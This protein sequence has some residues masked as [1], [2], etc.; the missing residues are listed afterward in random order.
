MLDLYHAE[1]TGDSARVLIV[2]EEKGVEFRSHYVDV[3]ALERYRPPLA[4]IAPGGELP[5]LVRA[6]VASTGASA[7]CELLEEAFPERA[8]M[9][10]GA[11]ERWCVR[12]WQKHV[13]DI[14][15][16]AVSVLAWEQYRER[17]LVPQARAELERAL[18]PAVPSDE[19]PRWRAAL[20]G[21]GAEQLARAAAHVAEGVLKVEAALGAGEWL[22][23]PGYSLAD[24]A[25]FA[26]FKYLTVI[27]GAHLAGPKAP[28][29]LAWL[30][31]VTERPAVRAALA[32]GREADPFAAASPAPEG[33]RW[34]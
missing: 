16:P 31:A 8:L 6:G 25:V 32:R 19:R 5:V 15:A 2:L 24:V 18:D 9:P 21:Y 11:R 30:R 1:P 22:A 34:G 10:Q 12:V 29:T 27:G 3:L 28:R 13:D 17:S 23:G 14:L 26:H 4:Q 20:A 7:L 33:I